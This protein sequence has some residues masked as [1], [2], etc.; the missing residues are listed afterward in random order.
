MLKRLVLIL[1]IQGL[2]LPL[3]IASA[4]KTHT[5][6]CAEKGCIYAKAEEQEASARNGNILKT[7]GL[8]IVVLAGSFY[9]SKQRGSKLY[10]LGGAVV[11]IALV[12]SIAFAP[13]KNAMSENIA[14]PTFNP[15]DTIGKN[16]FLPPGDEF[17]DESQSFN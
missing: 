1:L 5:S 4:A 2:M 16:V 13:R 8:A 12:A 9:L 15:N 10:L 6:S 17:I 3:I 14:C 11:S 7:A